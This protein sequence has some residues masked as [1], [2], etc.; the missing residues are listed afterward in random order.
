[1][2]AAGAFAPMN[3]KRTPPTR[4]RIAVALAD[5]GALAAP[6]S[7][8]ARTGGFAAGLGGAAESLGGGGGQVIAPSLITVVPR[9]TSSSMLTLI[10]PSFALQSSSVRRSRLVDRKSTRLNSSHPSISYAVFC[11]KKKKKAH[12][13]LTC[14]PSSDVH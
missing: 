11:L 1:M 5:A 8:S 10:A 13:V 4:N 3:Q 6:C 2:N 9:I 12:I 7:V 14:R